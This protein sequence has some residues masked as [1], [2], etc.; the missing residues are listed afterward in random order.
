LG[1]ATEA[2]AAETGNWDRGKL[3]GFLSGLLT[4]ERY[5]AIFTLLP[6]AEAHGHHR[7][8]AILA[9][10][11]V[12]N[13]LDG[14]RPLI[15]GIEPRAFEQFWLFEASGKDA[16]ERLPRLQALLRTPAQLAAAF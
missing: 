11:T 8:A 6:T 15:F 14:D 10:E 9:L 2:A 3:R 16:I 1:F 5:D 13:L 7:A 12:S 4:R